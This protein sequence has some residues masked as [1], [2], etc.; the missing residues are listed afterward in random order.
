MNTDI[1]YEEAMELI[2]KRIAEYPMVQKLIEDPEYQKALSGIIE[3]KG[4]SDDLFPHIEH[5]I[6]VVLAF[7]APLSELAQNIS[8]STGLSL[9]TSEELVILFEASLFAPI[10]DELYAFE[11]L[12]DMQTVLENG[13]P[14]A[15]KKLREE[16]ILRPSGVPVGAPLSNTQQN[17]PDTTV[18]E[19]AILPEAPKDIRE[20][21]ELRPEGVP[22]GAPIIETSKQTNVLGQV[23]NSAQVAGDEVLLKQSDGTPVPNT[24]ETPRPLTREEV[25]SALSPTRTM[26][27]D[28]A[29]IQT[30]SAPSSTPTP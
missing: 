2:Q 10:R 30:N 11:H 19:T 14:N 4:I 29:S 22:V 15:T 3:F 27:Q 17:N 26:A 18:V 20:A 23:E 24:L 9:E 1:T 7:Y 16:L 25:L 8:D 21:L 13:I 6:L 28:I 12:W 5:A